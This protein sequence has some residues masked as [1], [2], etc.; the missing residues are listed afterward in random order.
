M[1]KTILL[2]LP[3]LACAILSILIASF[4]LPLWPFVFYIILL[5]DLALFAFDFYVFMKASRHPVNLYLVAFLAAFAFSLALFL[6][7]VSRNWQWDFLIAFTCAYACALLLKLDHKVF[8][9]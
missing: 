4:I 9:K 8:S 6:I 2:F 5:L 1:K 3:D 7:E